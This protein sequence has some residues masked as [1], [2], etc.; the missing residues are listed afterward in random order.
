[1]HS[2]S[3][4]H[5]CKHACMHT[6]LCMQNHACMHAC[7]HACILVRLKEKRGCLFLFPCMKCCKGNEAGLVRMHAC[8]HSCMHA[9]TASMHALHACMHALLSCCACM[10]GCFLFVCLNVGLLMTQQETAEELTS[11]TGERRCL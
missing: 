8:M 5:A 9:N 6:A 7:M 1:M 10:A 3:C 4:M 2:Y 11:A